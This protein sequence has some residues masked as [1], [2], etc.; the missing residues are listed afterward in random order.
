MIIYLDESKKLWEG[1]IVLGGFITKHKHSY[2]NKFVKNKISEYGIKNVALELKSTKA[3]WKI[4]YEKMIKDNRFDIIKNNIIWINVT[5]Y[6]KDNLKQYIKI[7][8]ELIWYIYPSLKNYNK[9]IYFIADRIDFWKKTKMIEK[10]IEEKIN[11]KFKFKKSLYFQFESS[12]S[13]SGIQISDLITYQLRISNIN[14]DGVLDDFITEN[15]YNID[16][17]GEFKA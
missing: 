15:S 5:N 17:L 2:I 11:N 10:L 1:R 16:L 4:F 3:T 13:Y 9:N 6:Y 7:V 12:K 14:N 8:S